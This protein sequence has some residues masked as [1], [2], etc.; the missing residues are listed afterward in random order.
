[1]TRSSSS[2]ANKPAGNDSQTIVSWPL[3]SRQITK[4]IA[5]LSLDATKPDCDT[6]HIITDDSNMHSF[7]ESLEEAGA[8]GGHNLRGR[9]V[10]K[11][12]LPECTCSGLEHL[13]D[14]HALTW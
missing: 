6:S 8:E 5:T 13:V 2:V 4:A 3:R 7:P 11:V 14:A 12:D 9:F 1:M 10:G